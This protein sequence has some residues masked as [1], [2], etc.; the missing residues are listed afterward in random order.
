[1][2]ETT[3]KNKLL[4]EVRLRLG[5]GMIDLYL[6][7]GHYDLALELALDRYRQRSGNA[8]EESFIFLD[9]QP[10]VAVYT[11]PSEVEDVFMIYRRNLGATAG[12]GSAID[13]FSLAFTNNLYMIGNPGGLGGG[14]TGFLALYEMATSF[15]KL[16][17][18]M[19]GQ[20]L[21]FTWNRS[22]HRIMLHR[23]IQAV[24]EVCLHV[25]N[26]KPLDQLLADTLS[27]PWIRDYTIAQ[28]KLMMAEAFSRF[29]NI[30]GP[31]GGFT[32]NGDQLKQE[33][34]EELERLENELKAFT[35]NTGG[36]PFIIG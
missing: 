1:M 27:R 33:A 8:V 17:G 16:A 12:G 19:F 3:S 21:M 18:R 5:D 4:D 36:M 23:R 6:D 29:S 28:C 11:L 20:D 7:P 26:L 13:P 25:Y 24:E 32:L 2:T 30:G 14:G 35:D 10:D 22:S 15:Q 31:Q 34:K 9:V